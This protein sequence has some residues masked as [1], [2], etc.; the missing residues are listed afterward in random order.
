VSHDQRVE[1]IPRKLSFSRDILAQGKATYADI[2]KRLTMAEGGRWVWHADRPPLQRGTPFA[3]RGRGAGIQYQGRPQR[4]PAPLPRH[5][6]PPLQATV[7]D[8][9]VVGAPGPNHRV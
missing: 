2:L 6:V 9:Q 3:Q 5:P 7:G 4:P 8:N 1:G